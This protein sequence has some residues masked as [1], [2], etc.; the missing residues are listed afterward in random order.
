M[1]LKC[2]VNGCEA[3][4]FQLA[5]IENQFTVLICSSGHVI[6]RDYSSELHKLTSE[7]RSMN[8]SL[9]MALSG[10]SQTVAAHAGPLRKQLNEIQELLKK[11]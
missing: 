7:L 10:V 8:E 5:S 2:P 4:A 3:A 1:H 6:G 11:E 9:S